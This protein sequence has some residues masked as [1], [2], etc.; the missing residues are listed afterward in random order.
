MLNPTQIKEICESR[1]KRT[2]I[3]PDGVKKVSN[4]NMYKWLQYAWKGNHPA[5]KMREELLEGKVIVLNYDC[6]TVQKVEK[7]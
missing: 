2:I 1:L 4:V 7:I 5:S 6:G 3:N